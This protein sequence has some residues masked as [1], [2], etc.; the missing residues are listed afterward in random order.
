VARGDQ[1]CHQHYSGNKL[2][3]HRSND[4]KSAGIG[5][6]FSQISIGK[7]QAK[8]SLRVSAFLCALCGEG[9]IL[10]SFVSIG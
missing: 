3:S 2:S 10:L 8:F 6:F 9:L 1:Q 4:I 7:N 5:S